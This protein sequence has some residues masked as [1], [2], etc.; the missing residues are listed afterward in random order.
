MFAKKETLRNLATVVS[1]GAATFGM[2]GCPRS[3]SDT[4][5][6]RPDAGP[7]PQVDTRSQPSPVGLTMSGGIGIRIGDGPMAI[8]LSNGGISFMP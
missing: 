3:A 1:L 5:A 2:T 6:S 8:D 7:A 4:R